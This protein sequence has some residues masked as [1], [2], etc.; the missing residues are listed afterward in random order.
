LRRIEADGSM[1]EIHPGAQRLLDFVEFRI[2][3]LGQL[4]E[5]AGRISKSG[6]DAEFGHNLSDYSALLDEVRGEFTGGGPDSRVLKGSLEQDSVNKLPADGDEVTDWVLTYED[7][8]DES[9]HHAL[10]EWQKTQRVPWLVASLA[11][12]P[13]NDKESS[14][15]IAAAR[16][17]PVDSPA[18]LTATFARLRLEAAVDANAGAQDLDRVLNNKKVGVPKSSRNLLL[19]LGMNTAGSPQDFLRYAP[20]V[21]SAVTDGIDGLEVPSNAD[22]AL[23]NSAYRETLKKLSASNP[24]FDWDGAEVLDRELPLSA[25]AEAARSTTLPA[26]LRI[27]VAR[28]GW[29]RAVLLHDDSVK[30]FAAVLMEIDV[31][32]RPAMQ[33]FLKAQGADEEHHAAIFIVLRNPGLRPYVTPG[34]LR[35]GVARMDSY[36]DNWWCGLSTTDSQVGA[37]REVDGANPRPGDPLFTIYP[38]HVV[39]PPRFV[40]DIEKQRARTEL[41]ALHRLDTAP[42]YLVKETLAWAKARRDDPRV[43]EAFYWAVRATRYGCTDVDSSKLSRQ[44][45]VFLHKNYPED[46]FTAKTKYWY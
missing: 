5:L 11:K 28:A 40:G 17:L 18:Y 44:A 36:R 15:L 8:S 6:D 23:G 2:H 19:A 7:S 43:P 37:P 26:A 20:R 22:E 45:F 29:T 46:P 31:D 34:I 27:D 1:R 35:E 16:K 14:A 3:P 4:R 41:A 21:P 32:L 25:L 10:E 33:G 30:N 9:F 38:E 13:A 42:N 39:G 12:A 24:Y